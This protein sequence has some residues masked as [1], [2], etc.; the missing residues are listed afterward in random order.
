[1]TT[2]DANFDPYMNLALSEPVP[3]VPLGTLPPLSSDTPAL[4]AAADDPEA[5]PS[6]V[7]S[8]AGLAVQALDTGRVLMLQRALD[9]EDPASGTFEFPGG[10]IE[11]GETPLEG[12][13]REWTEETGM[14]A[15]TL[16][17]VGGWV[18]PDGVYEAFVVQ[19]PAE[20][21]LLL[22]PDSHQHADGN[23]D[24]PDRETPEVTLWLTQEDV[25]AMGDAIRQEVR[26]GTDW[27][28]FV[29]TVVAPVTD[30]QD[31][32]ALTASGDYDWAAALVNARLD[33]APYA[34]LAD[35]FG[36]TSA[37]AA[38]KA[39]MRALEA[40]ERPAD[41]VEAPVFTA[42]ADNALVAAEEPLPEDMPVPAGEVPALAQDI[43]PEGE[44]FY[45]IVAPEGVFSDDARGFGIEAF[46]TRDLPLP[47]MYQDA[48]QAGHDG[49]V[50]VGRI[51]NVWRDAETYEIPM[52]RYD[53]VWDTSDIAAEAKRQVEKGVA[54]G[55][56]VDGVDVTTRLVDSAG[57]TIDPLTDEPPE[58]GVVNE[59]A[60]AV[61][62]AGL[63]ICSVPAFEQTYIANG[64]YEDRTEP[65]PGQTPREPL[66][67]GGPDG[68]GAEAPDHGEDPQ[69][70]EA[71]V[72]AATTTERAPTWTLG[73]VASAEGDGDWVVPAAH[74]TDPGLET[75]T[76]LTVTPEG[77]VYG[78]LATWGQCHIGT[79]AGRRGE[80]VKAAGKCMEVPTSA[81]GY[82]FF[83]TGVVH[84][85]DG[86]MVNVGQLTMDTGHANLRYSASDTVDHYD[87]TG[88]P[89]ADIV[90]GHDAI[91]IWFSG[92]VRPT[93]T[94]QQVYSMTASGS[95]SG[96]WR[97]VVRRSNQL[98]LVAALVVNVPGFPIGRPAV[99]RS[100]GGPVSLV[101]SGAVV[102]ETPVSVGTATVELATPDGTALVASI[103]R[104]V[105]ASIARQQRAQAAARRVRTHRALK[106]AARLNRKGA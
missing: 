21:D 33:G 15:P 43:D 90:V 52:V 82:A 19:I 68:P 11:D 97:E 38:R 7:P 30:E 14:L 87:N 89:V 48:Q 1:M 20:A 51:D 86:G 60:D 80:Q 29:P 56:S 73:L 71:L 99:T 55:V 76:A 36:Y 63:T 54:K 47:L 104:E 61:K 12:A 13:R 45:G 16:D 62:M 88:S 85:D 91:G 32:E 94:P 8:H 106:A 75:A 2:T 103:T 72:A 84:T 44:P 9:P 50:R 42:T 10:S 3:D 100:A 79:A 27:T 96:D 39:L 64:R 53:G 22:N 6:A 58:D 98:E 66:P 65:E 34:E 17:P 105:I 28:Q 77:R 93:A 18:S 49:A 23:P 26:E 67:T 92:H 83:A 69:E 101:A 95:V 57:N 40:A 5:T 70:A 41:P 78:H 102:P 25:A 35:R 4:T 24:D 59:M 81:S 46:V 31:V 74:F 37:G